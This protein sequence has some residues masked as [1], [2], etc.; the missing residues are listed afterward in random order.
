MCVYQSL[1]KAIK[2]PGYIIFTGFKVLDDVEIHL[3]YVLSPSM[4]HWHPLRFEFKK[5]DGEI[6]EY[7]LKDVVGY[8]CISVACRRMMVFLWILN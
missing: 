1:S 5:N 3:V 8:A 4:S 2:L 7:F 6:L